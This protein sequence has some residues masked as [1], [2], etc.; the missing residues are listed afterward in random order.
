[1]NFQLQRNDQTTVIN[2][3]TEFI[4]FYYS[5]LNSKN[6]NNRLPYLKPYTIFSAQKIRYEGNKILNYFEILKNINA[7]FTNID[8]DTMHSGSRRINV[9]VTGI[10]NYTENNIQTTKNF[11]EYIHFGNDSDG[12]LWIQT[13][14][15]KII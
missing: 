15:F 7:T 5:T 11:S 4:N 13:L 6:F 2:L 10:I 3:T 9:L 14:M 8:Y 12:V 1:M